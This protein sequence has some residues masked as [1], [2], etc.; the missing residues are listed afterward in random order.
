MS[1]TKLP[2]DFDTTLYKPENAYWLA[3]AANLVYY[4]EGD[5]TGNE[6]DVAP[7][8]PRILEKLK[9]LDPRF[10]TV[11]SFNCKS[12]QGIVIQHEDYV[13]AAFRGTDQLI[14]WLDNVNIFP[15]KGPLGNVH[16]GFYNALLDLW[17]EDGMWERIQKLR[18]RG[19][20]AN[21]SDLPLWLQGLKQPKRPLWLTGHSLGGAM[22]TLAAAWLAERKIPFNGAYTFGQPRCGDENFQVAFN[23]KLNKIFFRFQNNNDIVTRVPARLMGYEH[24]GR[25]IY[26]TQDRELK[27]DISWWHKF[28]DRL[29]GVVDNIKDNKIRLE[30]IDD[31]RLE[32]EYIE[33]I[34]AWGN[35][36]PEKWERFSEEQ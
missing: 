4:K 11:E 25:Y 17:K 1:V 19:D 22:A 31:H 8:E 36:M 5:V 20:V 26:I 27:A 14:D 15:M 24:V 12:S 23:A 16:S 13:V 34:K 7:D 30:M 18:E 3:I 35:K 10:M 28:V 32:Q 9:S 21:K 6:K 33:A 29:E 2:F